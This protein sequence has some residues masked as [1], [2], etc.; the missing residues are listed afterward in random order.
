[1]YIRSV[2]G[3]IL[4]LILILIHTIA[5]RVAL[6]SRSRIER[7]RDCVSTGTRSA[8][9]GHRVYG[10]RRWLNGVRARVQRWCVVQRNSSAIRVECAWCLNAFAVYH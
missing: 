6:R 1:M 7:R 3:L 8:A 2:S 4:I 5:L 9:T 10:Y